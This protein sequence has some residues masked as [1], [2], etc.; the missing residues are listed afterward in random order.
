[1]GNV[2]GELGQAPCPFARVGAVE[3]PPQPWCPAVFK[4]AS[5]AVWHCIESCLP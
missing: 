5:D 3:Q 4:A 1:M 2:G